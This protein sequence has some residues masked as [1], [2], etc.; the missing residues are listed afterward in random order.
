MA[1]DFVSNS[2]FWLTQVVLNVNVDENAATYAPLTERKLK[3]PLD[4]EIVE[5]LKYTI[6][7]IG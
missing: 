2:A 7:F 1:Y 3:L 5:T 6:F 4:V